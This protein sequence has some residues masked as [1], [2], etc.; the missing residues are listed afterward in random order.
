M[1]LVNIRATVECDSCA[2]HMIIELDAAS[3]RPQNWSWFDL[4]EDAVRGGNA[5]V[6]M[7]G[8]AN[9]IGFTSVQDNKSLCPDCT[10]DADKSA[11]GDEE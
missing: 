5:L 11:G 7:R 9:A 4:A 6:S 8:V 1:A 2:R 10:R 3:Q